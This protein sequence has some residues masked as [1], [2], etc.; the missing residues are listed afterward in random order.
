MSQ[1]GSRRMGGR[2]ARRQVR[3][4]ALPENLK[5]VRAGQESG[6]YLPLQENELDLIHEQVI[7]VLEKIGLADAIP[8]CI[9]VMTAQACTM[10]ESGRLLIPRK[11]IEETLEKATKEMT[12]YGPTPDHDMLLSGSRTYFG[13]AGAAVHIV[14]PQTRTYRDSTVK[15][16][17]DLARLCDKLEHIHFF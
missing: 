1:T 3:A 5:S 17:Y 8:S 11:V 2:K 16:L 6:R 13:T 12:L 4:M 10:T 9:E 15:D 14:E 7:R